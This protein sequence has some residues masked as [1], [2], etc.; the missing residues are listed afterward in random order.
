MKAALMTV[1]ATGAL[2]L[3]LGLAIW[4]DS[5]PPALVPLHMLLGI[6]LVVALVAAAVLGLRAGVSPALA[7]LAIVWALVTPLL[8]LN[9]AALLPDAHVV[10]EIVHLLV[11]IG[12]IGIGEMLGARARQTTATGG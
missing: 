2:G 12:A 9:Q 1:R 11:G 4:T 6:V 7:G 3:L 8:G 5:A 10:V